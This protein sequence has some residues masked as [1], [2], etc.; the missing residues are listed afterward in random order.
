MQPKVSQADSHNIRPP[1]L[2]ADVINGSPQMERGKLS[3]LYSTFLALSS[4]LL[5][6]SRVLASHI[7]IYAASPPLAANC[8]YCKIWLRR[9]SSPTSLEGQTRKQNVKF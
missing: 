2:S 1:P 8:R 4:V 6:L 3:V 5:T 7:L 9:N